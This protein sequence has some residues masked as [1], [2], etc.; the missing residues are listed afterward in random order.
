MRLRP[1][2]R[3]KRGEGRGSETESHNDESKIFSTAAMK[4]L[5]LV[6]Q[7]ILLPLSPGVGYYI[8]VLTTLS[9]RCIYQEKLSG[10]KITKSCHENVKIYT[11]LRTHHAYETT[12]TTH[13]HTHTHAHNSSHFINSLANSFDEE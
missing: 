3:G 1:R 8:A 4:F 11:I 12:T 6:V 9:G 13:T 5:N 7:M 10:R 2:G